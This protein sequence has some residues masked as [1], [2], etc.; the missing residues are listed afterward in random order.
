MGVWIETVKL[1]DEL[2]NYKVTPY[3]GVW[4]ETL[5]SL[6]YTG[7]TLSLLMWECGL[8]QLKTYIFIFTNVTPY[9]GVWIETLRK[10]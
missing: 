10:S 2:D 5:N 1:L 8:K 6:I 9:V 7:L 3:V 4:I